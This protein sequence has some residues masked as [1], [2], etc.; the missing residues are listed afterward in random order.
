[1]K[2]FAS[3]VTACLSVFLA[4]ISS[5]QAGKTKL[6]VLLYPWVPDYQHIAQ[7][8]EQRFE[9]ENPTVDLVLSEQN[10]NYYQP[11]GLD[12]PYD[13]YELDGIY[14]R[15]FVE[16]GRLQPLDSSAGPF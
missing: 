11:G 2:F 12:A 7:I 13:I 4:C 8:L 9:S 1:M 15:D 14:L 5:A 6:T 16:A 10:W 3:F